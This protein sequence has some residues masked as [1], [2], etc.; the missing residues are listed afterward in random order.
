MLKDKITI[1]GDIHGRTIW[2][3]IVEKEKDSDLFIFLG[4]Y[5]DSYSLVTPGA[6]V[7]N[8]I[9]ILN[10]KLTNPEKVTLLI[11]N[12]DLHYITD[13]RATRWSIK[14]QELLN[15][16][17][18]KELINNNVLQACKN[19]KHVTD[20]WFTHAG[21]SNTWLRNHRLMLYEKEINDA[22]IVNPKWFDFSN[23][24]FADPYGDDVFQSPVWIR[25]DSLEKDNPYG[26]TQF[27]GHTQNM[28]YWFSGLKNVNYC[29]SLE[30]NMYYVYEHNPITMNYEY[31]LKKI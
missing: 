23:H 17:N 3:N 19:V 8:F 27:V 12:H 31:K 2:K 26:I 10:F 29:D 16:L 24:R 7:N 22:L 4:D 13:C 25:P 28:N 14:T 15:D 21:L 5:V 30:W 9:D 20:M 1:I 18:F 6:Q 11:G